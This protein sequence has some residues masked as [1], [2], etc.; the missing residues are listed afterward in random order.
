MIQPPPPPLAPLSYTPPTPGEITD[1]GR[2]VIRPL[3]TALD[4]LVQCFQDLEESPNESLRYYYT[5]RFLEILGDPSR[6]PLQPIL[7]PSSHFEDNILRLLHDIS[8][9]IKEI[10]RTTTPTEPAPPASIADVAPVVAAMSE[11]IE[12]LKRETSST[13]KMSQITPYFCHFPITISSHDKVPFPTQQT[14][15][16]L[17]IKIPFLNHSRHIKQHEDIIKKS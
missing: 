8:T 7:Y 12:N 9:E 3:E 6:A 17:I 11:T 15:N 13:L 5:S 16:T 2:L 10:P 1:F 4:N 14:S